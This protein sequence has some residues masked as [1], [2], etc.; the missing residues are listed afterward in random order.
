VIFTSLPDQRPAGRL[1]RGN[2]EVSAK[3]ELTEEATIRQGEG[4]T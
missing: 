3:R 2:D 1:G 4:N